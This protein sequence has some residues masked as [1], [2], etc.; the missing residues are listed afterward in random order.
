[1]NLNAT[2]FVQTL[3]FLILAW[4][5]MKFVWPPLMKAIEERQRKIADGLAAADRARKELADADARATDELKKAQSEA[6]LIRDRAEK[7]AAQIVDKARSDAGSE[8][9]KLRAAAEAEIANLSFKA[10]EVLRQQVAALAVAGAEKILA[11]EIDANRH[12]DLLDALAH[13]I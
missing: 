4:F 1:M 9:Q 7:Q 3:V 5:T 8:A 13:E 11:R 10:R 12:R 2:L 6:A